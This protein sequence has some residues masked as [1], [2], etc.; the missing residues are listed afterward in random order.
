MQDIRRGLIIVNTGPG[1]GKTTAAMGTA[2]LY[3]VGSDAA[4]Y[5]A[6]SMMALGIMTVV[7]SSIQPLAGW[8]I[9]QAASSASC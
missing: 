9:S 5:S 1:K 8:V 3:E 2:Y 4:P 7:F 6:L